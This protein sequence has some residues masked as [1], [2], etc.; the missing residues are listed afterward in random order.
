MSQKT[1]HS[2]NSLYVTCPQ[3]WYWQYKEGYEATTMGSSLYFGT[4]IDT[5]ITH[6]LAGQTDYIPKFYDKWEFQ[7]SNGKPTKIFDND[8]I[9]Y[10][11]K[12]FDGDLLE[13]KDFPELEKWA[14]ELKLLPP[15]Q[16]ISTQDLIDLFKSCSKAK[17]NPYIKMTDEQFKYFNRCSW[18]SLKR[19]G[20]ILIEAFH[21]QFFPKIK[22]VIAT[23]KRSKIEDHSTGDSIVGYIDMILEIDG[24][25]KPIIFDLK[26][27]SF[28][29]D[30]TQLDLSQQLTLYAAMEAKNY[31]TDLVGF[32]VLNKNIQKDEVGHCLSCGKVKS[33]RHKTCDNMLPNNVR[34]NG[35]WLETKVPNPQVQ[36]LIQ[37]KTPDQINAVLLDSGAII[38]AMKQGIVY[39]NVSKCMDW[40]GGIC[41]FYNLCHKND[42]TGL[43]KKK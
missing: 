20:K 25:D 36:V 39:K 23:Q 7:M 31:N 37:A 43:T 9:T 38:H 35:A 16:V 21:K 13:P 8:N 26:T 40:Y 34:C 10:S 42:A 27:S 17:S 24:Y 28:P 18:L 12:D 2:Q 33:T 15:T 14:I 22:K 11:H 1:S 29:Y 19:K 30:Q 4:A 41:G 6:M 3:A 32:I 5:A